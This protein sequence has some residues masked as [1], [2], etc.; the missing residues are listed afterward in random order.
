M[1]SNC[2][3]DV[4]VDTEKSDQEHEKNDV[5]EEILVPVVS[6]LERR[7]W[8]NMFEEASDLL[9]VSIL[10]YGIAECRKLVR[11]GKMTLQAPKLSLPV[12][13]ADA[14]HQLALHLDQ[15]K[16]LLEPESFHLYMTGTNAIV[17]K[18]MAIA[19]A[20]DDTDPSMIVVFDDE[21]EERELVYSIQ[22][23]T[24]QRRITV[25]FRGSVTLRDMVIDSKAALVQIPNPVNP[26]TTIGIHNG[27][28]DY[29]Y[30]KQSRQ[31]GASGNG[32]GRK[33]DTIL[34]QLFAVI[35]MYPGY[36]IA[37]TGH[38]LGGSLATLLALE[39]G[40][41]Q[42]HRILDPITCITF[43]A[44][45]VGNFAFAHAFQSLER[46]R[47]IRCLSVANDKDIFPQIPRRGT[48]NPCGIICFG[49]LTYWHVGV[50]LTLMQN[51]GGYRIY[52]PRHFGGRVQSFVRACKSGHSLWP[53]LCRENLAAN[54]SCME[55]WTRLIL[56][57]TA[58]EK[59]YLQHEYLRLAGRRFSFS[60]SET[61]LH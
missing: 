55:Y 37:I 54:H 21:N 38:S 28:R 8:Q 50:S 35:D 46:C 58:L 57:A 56:N 5:L 53:L 48:K 9:A 61:G 32:Q 44:P 13:I 18:Y 42:D 34:D 3:D 17:D 47:R 15:I 27:F 4:V 51:D 2:S 23:N 6:P 14:A 40:A 31:P 7:Q 36:C 22:V 33:I 11:L 41:I 30:G 20:S 1:T 45:R 52:F 12:S 26:G 43:A 59:V 25:A 49:D 39:L 16:R 29:L 19:V 60:E 10:I 24:K